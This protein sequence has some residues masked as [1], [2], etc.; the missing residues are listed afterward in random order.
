MNERWC[1]RCGRQSPSPFAKK[2]ADRYYMGGHVL[3]IGCGNG[4]NSEFMREFMDDHLKEPDEYAVYGLDMACETPECEKIILGKDKFPDSIPDIKYVMAN[5]ILMF[6]DDKEMKQVVGEINRVAN[7]KWCTCIVEM[8]PAKDSHCKTDEECE[9]KLDKF[10]GM[11]KK[12]AV[13]WRVV[14]RIKLRLVM[15]K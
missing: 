6:L 5:Y 8:Y 2:M 10:V 3:D 4:R 1:V 14:K 7:R 13:G 15:E 11:M 9:K 12:E